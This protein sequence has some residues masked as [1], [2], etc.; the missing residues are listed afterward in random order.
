MAC[1]A[2]VGVAAGEACD[3][4]G[5]RSENGHGDFTIAE[6]LRPYRSLRQRLQELVCL[7]GVG[8]AAGV[9]AISPGRVRRTAAAISRSL[10]AFGLI[11]ACGSGYRSWY[12]LQALV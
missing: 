5:P 7:T 9:P 10:K 11:A 6:G 8:V 12:A 2:G 4:P 3:R 1:L